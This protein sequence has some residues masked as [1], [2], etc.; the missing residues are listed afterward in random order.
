MNKRRAII[1]CGF[2]AIG[3]TKISEINS[4]YEKDFYSILDA[5][6]DPYKKMYNRNCMDVN[7]PENYIKFIKRKLYEYDFI[8]TPS[9]EYI[10]DALYK[11]GLD[12]M[13]VYPNNSLRE[14]YVS[15][16]YLGLNNFAKIAR[17]TDNWYDDIK[18]IKK[19]KFAIKKIELGYGEYINLNILTKLYLHVYPDFIKRA[20]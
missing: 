8:L 3:K 2:T 7:Y 16:L 15:R 6:I 5:N 12:Y 10:R 11:E 4:N 18:S 13:I 20:L 14:E 17:L 9:D 19:D 1:I